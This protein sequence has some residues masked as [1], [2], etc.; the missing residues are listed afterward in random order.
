MIQVK[1][2]NIAIDPLTGASI[3]LLEDINDEKAIY[4]IWIG[5]AEAEGIVIN[6]AGIKTPR[7]LTYDLM[8]NIILEL[9]GVVKEVA[10]IDMVENAYIAR[11]YIEQNGKIL[12]IDSRPSDA[13]NLA[14]RFGAPIYLNEEVV[15]KI[16]PE[17]LKQPEK[18]EEN[19]QPEEVKQEQPKVETQTATVN[20]SL[21]DEEMKKLK[22]FLEKVKP[23]DFM[24]NG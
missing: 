9:G 7:P 17:E 1:V 24:L 5:T 21:E 13:I 11:V 18:V 23:E 16:E 8:K 3:V 19:K 10:I 12:E 6:Q 4:P 14:L 20:E 2:K 22:E 15:K